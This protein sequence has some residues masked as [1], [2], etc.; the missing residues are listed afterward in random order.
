MSTATKIDPTTAATPTA[1]TFREASAAF[2]AATA[3]YRKLYWSAEYLA[4][5]ALEANR[6]ADD[7]IGLR[8]FKATAGGKRACLVLIGLHWPHLSRLPERT[9]FILAVRESALG[10]LR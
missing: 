1:T 10:C 2:L 8:W 6:R 3:K 9:R 5:P 4:L 7:A